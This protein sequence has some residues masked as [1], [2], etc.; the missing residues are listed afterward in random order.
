MPTRVQD[1]APPRAVDLRQKRFDQAGEKTKR[2]AHNLSPALRAAIC[3]SLKKHENE[4]R[5]LHEPIC[6][7]FGTSVSSPT[8]PTY[9]LYDQVKAVEVRLYTLLSDHLRWGCRF[10]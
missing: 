4:A 5:C 10:G 7:A 2:G 1:N 6:I 8:V 9:Q 3:R